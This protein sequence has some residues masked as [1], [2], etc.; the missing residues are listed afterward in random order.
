M[1]SSL[2]ALTERYLPYDRGSW[3]VEEDGCGNSAAL[4]ER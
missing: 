1:L 2:P 4:L 3:Q